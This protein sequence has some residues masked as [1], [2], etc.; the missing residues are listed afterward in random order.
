[1]VKNLPV[2]RELLL[3]L[4]CFSH[5]WP[6]A[7][8]QTA[9]HQASPSLGFSRQEHWSGLPLPS[10]AIRETQVQSP[11][12]GNGYPLQ[13]SCLEN[14]MD[15]G[16]WQA[17]V[18]G[19]K[20]VGHNWMTNSFFQVH[21]FAQLQTLHSMKFIPRHWSRILELERILRNIKLSLNMYRN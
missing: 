21:V 16:A 7:T 20:R 8:P 18:H 5:V 1:M 13:Y 10:P 17:T 12:E 6:C 4:S 15:R 14:P 19:S 9:A 2:I 11:A 3:L